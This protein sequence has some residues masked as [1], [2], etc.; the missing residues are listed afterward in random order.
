[1]A[2]TI[3]IRRIDAIIVEAEKTEL[4]LHAKVE[5]IKSN[6]DI[7][8]EAKTKLGMVFPESNQIIYFTLKDTERV[9]EEKGVVTSI[10]STLIGNRE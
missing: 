1:M 4:N 6:R 8:D 7:V 9:E 3:E 5:E 2:E 10:F